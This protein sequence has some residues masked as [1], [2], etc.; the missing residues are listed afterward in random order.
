MGQNLI[1]SLSTPA[2]WNPNYQKECTDLA[3]E[4]DTLQGILNNLD[5]EGTV[6]Q[7][8]E[9]WRGI[10]HTHTH[11]HTHTTNKNFAAGWQG[12]DGTDWAARVQTKEG[13]QEYTL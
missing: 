7:Y 1:A 13:Y 3:G 9:E 8:W 4:Q 6:S 10:S 11:I 12:H 2:E 5:S